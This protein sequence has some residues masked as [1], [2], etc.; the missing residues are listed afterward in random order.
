M[1]HIIFRRSAGR[2][3][4]LLHFQRYAWKSIPTHEASVSSPRESPSSPV[5][6]TEYPQL[7]YLITSQGLYLTALCKSATYLSSRGKKGDKAN[8][9][10][11]SLSPFTPDKNSSAIS[12]S[13]LLDYGSPQQMQGVQMKI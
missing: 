12:F 10:S 8:S 9:L 1:V 4:E 3:E 2:R 11:L 13:Y 6:L 5:K 7:S